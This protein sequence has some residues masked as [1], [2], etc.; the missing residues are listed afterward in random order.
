MIDLTDKIYVMMK[1]GRKIPRYKCVCRKCANTKIAK[2]VHL[3][4]VTSDETKA[5][6]SEAAMGNK[7]ALNNKWTTQQKQKLSKTKTGIKFSKEHCDN[8]GK[9]KKGQT[10]WNK[11]LKT[12]KPAWNRG[13]YFENKIK[14]VMRD[15]VSRRMRHAL[16]RRNLKKNGIHI[17]DLLGYSTDELVIHL[18]SKFQK[19]MNW[20]N[21]EEW[22]ID[23][24]KPESLFNYS[25]FNEPQFK[26]C[27]SLNNLQP[28]WAEDNLK[29]SNKFKG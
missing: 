26:E 7:N 17:F 16:E 22:H 15:R 13:P 19:G 28:L 29:K 27:W 18:E 1:S 10:P 14:K 4:K 21:R 6:M 2:S 20:D 25:D 12:N 5:K 9:S 23:H 3:G 24:I 8:I 11:D